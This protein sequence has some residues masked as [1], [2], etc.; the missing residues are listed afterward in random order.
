MIEQSIQIVRSNRKTLAVEIKSDLRIIVRA[1]LK[2][3]DRD[4]T[5]FM[6]SKEKWILEHLA[7]VRQRTQTDAIPFT[8]EE[9]NQLRRKAKNVVPCR[10]A[11]FA[12]MMG[13]TY[14]SITIRFQTS[15]YGSC[16]AKGNLNFNALL[17][18]MPP[19][20]MDYII[21]HELAHRKEMNHSMRFWAEVEKI[22]PN[23]KEQRAWVKEHGSALIQRLR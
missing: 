2:A 19:E 11:Y 15:R 8:E 5:A 4:I 9:L 18:L 12:E 13:V 17:V 7:R 14:N 1:P 16:S 20:A 10:A 22:L 3:T 23:Y 21:V 6:A